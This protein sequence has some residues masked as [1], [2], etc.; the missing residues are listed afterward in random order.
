MLF[1]I[2]WPLPEKKIARSP[3][4]IILPDSGGAAAPSLPSSYA[5][6][7]DVSQLPSSGHG[8]L[9][10]F[11]HDATPSCKTVLVKT[12]NERKGEKGKGFLFAFIF[13]RFPLLSLSFVACCRAISQITGRR[14][15]PL[16]QLSHLFR[17]LLTEF[18]S[19]F[20]PFRF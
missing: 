18:H 9:F 14:A 19:L 20:T 11:R 1:F 12:E 15:V 4:K 8:E 5:Y 3:E 13:A 2:F 17:L 10:V 7:D 6:D 16:R